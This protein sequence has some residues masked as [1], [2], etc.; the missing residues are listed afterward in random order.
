[1]EAVKKFMAGRGVGYYLSLLALICGIVGV[2]TYTATGTNSFNPELNVSCLVC[3]WLA[4][5]LCAATVAFDF[6]DIRYIAAMLF[7]YGFLMFIYSQVNYIA[8]VF[9]GIDGNVLTGE[10]F[11]AFV[12]MFLA[13]VLSLLAGILTKWR[14][15]TGRNAGTEVKNETV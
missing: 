3:C 15:W 13:F 8:N 12:T 6:K 11:C 7:L 14:P 4:V 5:A 1:M 9:V 10:F 2:A